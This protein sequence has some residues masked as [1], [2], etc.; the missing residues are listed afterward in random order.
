MAIDF[1]A[2]INYLLRIRGKG[3]GKRLKN[4][5]SSA[6]GRSGKRSR[7]WPEPFPGITGIKS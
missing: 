5:A 6:G 3:A 1:L 4:N 7:S 2:F